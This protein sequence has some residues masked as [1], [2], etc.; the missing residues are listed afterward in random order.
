MRDREPRTR[1]QEEKL[2]YERMNKEY[3][4]AH[5]RAKSINKK[6]EWRFFLVFYI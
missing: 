4:L 5:P 6:S 1:Q 2:D 3:L